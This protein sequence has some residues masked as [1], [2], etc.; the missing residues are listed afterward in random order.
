MAT[1]EEL[2]EIII[3]LKMELAYASVPKGNCPYAYYPLIKEEHDCCEIDCTECKRRFF[4]KYK[5]TITKQVQ[6]L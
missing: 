1:I 2:K 3:G 5:E 4:E 6:E